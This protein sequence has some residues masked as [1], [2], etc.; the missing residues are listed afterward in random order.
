MIE[1]TEYRERM[2][3]TISAMLMGEDLWVVLS[4]HGRPHIGAVAVSLPRPSPA[5]A[6]AMAATTSVLAVVGHKEDQ[7]VRRTAARLAS[8]LGAAVIVS[9]GI[10]LEGASERTTENIAETV[11]A[12]TEDLID[13]VTFRRSI[14]TG[15]P[16]ALAAPP[17]G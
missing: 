11:A 13:A 8:T 4:G 2:R 10:H 15:G 9:C 16:C 5:G 1:I 3:L 14:P 7:I 12:M 6:G 17:P